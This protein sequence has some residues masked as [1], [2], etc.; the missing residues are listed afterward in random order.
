MKNVLWNVLKNSTNFLCLKFTF[1][2]PLV[3]FRAK[4]PL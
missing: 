3:N 1:L 2:S 4:I